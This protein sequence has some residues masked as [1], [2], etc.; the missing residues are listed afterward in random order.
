MSIEDRA[1]EHEAQMWEKINQ[2]RQ[3]QPTFSPGEAGYGPAECNE[4]G[5]DMPDVRRGY[6]YSICTACQSTHE[7]RAR[8]RHY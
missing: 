8:R 2:P 6:G 3:Q 1:Q 4:C 7:E 5:D